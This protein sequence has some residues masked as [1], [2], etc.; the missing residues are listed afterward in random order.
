MNH[1]GFVYLEGRGV[2]ADPAEALKLFRP[3]AGRGWA[4]AQFNLGYCYDRGLGVARDYAVAATCYQMAA[5]R[6][7]S[8]EFEK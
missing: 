6:R 5:G 3:A 1:L 8:R 2:P 7:D 4:N